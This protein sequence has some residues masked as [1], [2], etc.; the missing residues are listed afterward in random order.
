MLPVPSRDLE[1]L[2]TFDTKI[3]L[4]LGSPNIG[5]G[6]GE[7]IAKTV[8][9]VLNCTYEGTR[10]RNKREEALITVL[11]QVKGRSKGTERAKGDVAGRFAIDVE[12]GFVSLA[13]I[14]ISTEI[15]GTGSDFRMTFA[16]DVDLDRQPGNPLNIPPP[17]ERKTPA[18]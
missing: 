18:K 8:D 10:V 6:S 3:A 16:L 15:E 2:Q 1:P 13:Q 9:L 14:K 11:G 5:K 7:V 17:T 12:A 4:I